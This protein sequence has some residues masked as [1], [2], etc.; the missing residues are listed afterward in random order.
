MDGKSS[1]IRIGYVQKGRGLKGELL[2]ALASAEIEIEKGIRTIWLGGDSTQ[3]NPWEVEYLCPRGSNAILK[4][5]D[6]TSREQADFLRGMALYVEL[7]EVQMNTPV[8]VLGYAAI[9]ASDNTRIGTVTGIEASDFQQRLIVQNGEKTVEIPAVD[10]FIKSIDH[11][12]R[13]I[14]IALIDGMEG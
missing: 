5:K 11:K 3:V 9:S 12:D 6:V 4:L 10:E 8:D 2:V 14:K 13:V 1:K 7:R